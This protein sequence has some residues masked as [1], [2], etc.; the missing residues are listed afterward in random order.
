MSGKRGLRREGG[1]TQTV[2]R[3]LSPHGG[4]LG[5]HLNSV[6]IPVSVSFTA[7]VLGWLLW[8]EQGGGS[9]SEGLWSWGSPG[10]VLGESRGSPG[11]SSDDT[12]LFILHGGTEGG[13]AGKVEPCTRGT[14]G[15]GMDRQRWGEERPPLPWALTGR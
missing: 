13:T 2:E 5:V 12:S 4:T 15:T 10:G 7:G 6:Q 11:V 1:I 3:L 14:A 8:N 9:S